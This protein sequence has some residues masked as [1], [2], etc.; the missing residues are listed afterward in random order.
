MFGLGRLPSGGGFQALV[1]SA[2]CLHGGADGPADVALKLGPQFPV[3]RLVR[4]VRCEG[5]PDIPRGVGGEAVADLRG[6]AACR[7]PQC[8]GEGARPLAL[9]AGEGA[10]VEERPAVIWQQGQGLGYAVRLVRAGVW[11]EFVGEV[12]D[13]L[14]L[15]GRARE[16]GGG[17]ELAGAEGGVPDDDP[18]PC[19]STVPPPP[20]A[21]GDTPGS[22]SPRSWSKTTRNTRAT[23]PVTSRPHV[24]PAS[25]G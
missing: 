21:Y 12:D 20:D 7:A 15:A 13:R 1:V 3:L 18:G 10:R 5:A 25:L 11:H 8:R 6:L 19:S 24:M 14:E 16:R 17:E 23:A 4:Q 9:V 2:R 22:A